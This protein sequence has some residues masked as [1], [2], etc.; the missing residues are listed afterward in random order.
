MILYPAISQF[1]KGENEKIYFLE[2]FTQG[3][4]GIIRKWIQLDCETEI[5]ELVEIIKDCV[6]YKTDT[7][8]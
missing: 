4:A 2:F 8:Y 5:N 7:T 1:L 3:V 6:G